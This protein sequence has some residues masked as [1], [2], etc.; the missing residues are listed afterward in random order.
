MK[1]IYRKCASIVVLRKAGDSFEVLLLHKPRKKD[2]WQLPQGGVEEWE[3][4]EQA[5][6]R[7]LKEEAG[8]EVESAGQSEKIYQYD[9]PLAYRRFRPDNVCGQRL[10]FFFALVEP[11]AKVE[12][13]QSEINEFVWVT[14]EDVKKY[15]KRPEYSEL[16]ESMVEEGIELIRASN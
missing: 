6:V 4:Y 8:L 10:E 2:S 15:I 12:V 13:D 14:K 11:D 1:D 5:A 3:T 16:I 7:E 9:F